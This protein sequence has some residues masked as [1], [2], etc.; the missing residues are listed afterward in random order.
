VTDERVRRA[1]AVLAAGAHGPV[2]IDAPIGPMTSYRIG[3]PAGISLEV[4]G[5]DDLVAL[6]AAVAETGLSVLVIGR[7]SNVL[8]SDRGFPGI[9]VRLG[10]GYRW[11]RVDGT[12]VEAG[13]AMPLPALATTAMDH[14]LTGLEFG[15]AIPA[16]V[17]GA[18][19][20]N[21]GA[22]GTEIKDVLASAEV[23]VLPEARRRTIPVEE[24]GFAYRSSRFPSGAVV[25]GARFA[26]EP[27]DRQRIGARLHEV[28]EW[29]RANQPL[30]MPNGGSVFKNPPGDAA[31]RLVET[32]CGKGMRVGGASVSDV[33]AN[34]IVTDPRAR[35]DDV[36]TLI[37]RIQRR[38]LADAGV[39]LEPELKLVGEF[40]EVGD[41]SDA[42]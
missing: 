8:V 36:Y 9:V 32:I 21:A 17:G 34:F 31:G 40:Q 15:V 37:R 24:A 5:D 42:G 20:M 27:G 6:A 13:A 12:V 30:S 18:V 4:E 33:H 29:R 23:F 28:K 10:S 16:S 14:A 2:T 25:V 7:G 11:H 35:A 19:R 38:V 26:L 39:E 3:G 1:A 22:H 41:G